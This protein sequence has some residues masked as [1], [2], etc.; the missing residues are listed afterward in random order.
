[1]S[2]PSAAGRS[3]PVYHD[4]RETSAPLLLLGAV[5]VVGPFAVLSWLPGAGAFADLC[6]VAALLLAFAVLW[7]AFRRRAARLGMRIASGFG[8]AAVIAL[9]MLLTLGITVMYAGPFLL[10]GVGLLIAGWRLA[11][12]FLVVW[13]L[14]IGGVGV[15]EGFFGITNRLPASAWAPW[16]HEAIY[17]VLGTA[18]VLAG[19]VQ[20]RREDRRAQAL[21]AGT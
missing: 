17:L 21:R 8:A 12:R 6:T 11:N 18:T 19:M 15:F 16:E 13:A 4:P 2:A 10:F 1:M 14:A 20:W 9:A 7:L 5:L 3:V